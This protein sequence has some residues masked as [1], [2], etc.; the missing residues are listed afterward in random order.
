LLN[1]NLTIEVE[2]PWKFYE[3]FNDSIF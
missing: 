2:S 1:D 3:Q